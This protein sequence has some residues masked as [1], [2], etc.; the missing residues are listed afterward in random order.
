MPK[1]KNGYPDQK[2]MEHR[3]RNRYEGVSFPEG[4]IERA[5]TNRNPL[6]CRFLFRLYFQGRIKPFLF[7]GQLKKLDELE[8]QSQNKYDQSNLYQ[9]SPN[10]IDHEPLLVLFLFSAL[11]VCLY[12]PGS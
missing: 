10:K 7:L 8:D 1:E 9:L 2:D 12:V 4:S 3:C 11:A 6:S 5:E